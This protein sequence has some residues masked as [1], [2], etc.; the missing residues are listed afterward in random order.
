[1]PIGKGYPSGFD[2][3]FRHGKEEVSLT[4]EIACLAKLLSETVA[5]TLVARPSCLRMTA[6]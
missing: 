4:S 2:R 3:R 5:W 1:M 6:T